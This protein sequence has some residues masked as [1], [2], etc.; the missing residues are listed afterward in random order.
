[1]SPVKLEMPHGPEKVKKGHW[2]YVAADTKSGVR[3]TAMLIPRCP[4]IS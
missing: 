2:S 3:E 1:M 4:A